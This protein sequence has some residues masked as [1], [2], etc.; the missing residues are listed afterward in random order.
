VVEELTRPKR[1][2]NCAKFVSRGL[3]IR[4]FVCEAYSLLLCEISRRTQYHDHGILL[5]LNVARVGLDIRGDDS[6]SHRVEIVL[7]RETIDDDFLI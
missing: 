5:Q 6:V 7:A 4:L 3:T 1:A 2:G